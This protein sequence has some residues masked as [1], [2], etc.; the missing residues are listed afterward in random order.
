MPVPHGDARS[1]AWCA[2]CARRIRPSWPPGVEGW[3]LLDLKI[4]PYGVPVETKVTQ[5]S[6]STQ[7][8]QAAVRAAR[9]WRFAPPLWKSRPV[10]VTCRIEVRFHS[11]RDPHIHRDAAVNP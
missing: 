11:G 4:D 10:A 2:G 7:L 8:D 1:C 3:V 6:G 9:L 5:S